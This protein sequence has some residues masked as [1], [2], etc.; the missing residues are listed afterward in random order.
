MLVMAELIY[1]VISPCGALGYG[2]P[3]ESLN[4]ALKGPIDAVIADAGSLDAGPYHLGSGTGY[5]D[6]EAVKRDYHHMVEAGQRIEGPVILGSCGLAGGNRNLEWMV[7]I[8]K[9]VFAELGVRDARVALI[10]AEIDPEIVIGELRA[11]RLLGAGVGPEL[12]EEALRDSVIVGQMGIHPFITALSSGAKYIFAGRACNVALFASDMIRRGIDPGLAYHVGRVLR[13]GAL[14]CD[15]G[16]LAD[17]LVAEVYDDGTALFVSPNANRRCAPSS[18]A[19]HSLYE[20]N[21]PQLKLHPEGILT[22]EHTE[23]FTRD[24]RTAG[25]RNSQFVR[26]SKPWPYS[27]KLEGARRLGGRK[28]SMVKFD[29]KD[30][31]KIP[32]DILVYGRNGV[33]SEP[34]Q[35]PERELGFIIETSGRTQAAATSLANLISDQLVHHAYPGRKATTGNLGFPMSPPLATFRRRDGYYGAIVPSG[36]RDPVFNLN[37]AKIKAAVIREVAARFPD[38]LRHASYEI[39][40]ADAEHPIALLRSVAAD[41]VVLDRL[42]AAE[43]KRITRRLAPGVS[44][45]FSLDVPDAYE[46]TLHHVLQNE[47]IIK[48]SLFSITYFRANDSTWVHEGTEQPRYFDVGITGTAGNL[49][50]RTL[51]LIADA[52]PAGEPNGWQRLLD[53]ANVI[54]SKKAGINRITFDIFFNSAADYETALT[55]NVF[56]SANVARILRIAPERI[57][58]T[59]FVDTCNAIKISIDRADVSAS[60][61]ERDVFGTQ[62]QAKLA[63]LD[64]PMYADILTV[65]SSL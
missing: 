24:G 21:H 37:C 45:L 27:I 56:F 42:H 53:M 62:Q 57:V 51:S 60:L 48:E 36:T 15:P 63:H 5:F 7:E 41:P 10:S 38:A 55:S 59:F 30:L 8:G 20:E 43:I 17:C 6:R 14:A 1:R 18:I 4:A 49:D 44:S 35:L 32:S 52:P 2:F 33:G 11:G 29:A 3:I 54:R 28:V 50:D 58:G 61:D 65:A 26:S 16:S 40:D 39:I 64:I 23:F 34:V 12:S 47:Q 46:W 31:S 19:A 13:C 9:E 25:I 22:T